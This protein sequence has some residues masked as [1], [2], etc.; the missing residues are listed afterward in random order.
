MVLMSFTFLWIWQRCNIF[1]NSSAGI[2]V[3]YK[4][5]PGI[6]SANCCN[7]RGMVVKNKMVAYQLGWNIG[8]VWTVRTVKIHLCFK[9]NVFGAQS[10][11]IY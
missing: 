10:V 9:S 5:F 8:A 7:T 6:Y 11:I 4:N 3:W 2:S 1:L